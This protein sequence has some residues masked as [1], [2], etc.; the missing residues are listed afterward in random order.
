[1]TLIEI[2]RWNLKL[3]LGDAKVLFIWPAWCA[4]TFTAWMLWI[5]FVVDDMNVGEV[6]EKYDEELVKAEGMEKK[7][8]I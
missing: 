1:M 2:F 6:M 8:R 5:I 4:L 7:G 3:P